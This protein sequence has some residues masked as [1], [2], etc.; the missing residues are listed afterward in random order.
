MVRHGGVQRVKRLWR[1]EQSL[2]AQED[3]S[4]L[5]GRAPFVLQYIQA[6]ATKLVNVGVVDLCQEADLGR[7]H[8]IALR[9]EELKLI[10]TF[11]IGGT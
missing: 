9:Q 7:L 1:A 11:L 3:G 6:D 2:D 10:V 4:D 5:K 8:R